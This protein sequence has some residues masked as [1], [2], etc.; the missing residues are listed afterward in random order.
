MRD[1][2]LLACV[3]VIA[4]CGLVYE[5]LSA[6]LASYLLGDSVTQ[7]SL[8]I[9]VYLSAMGLGSYLSK[10]IED[11]I[12]DRFVDAQVVVA[13]FGGFAAPVLFFAFA[14]L[15]TVQPVL[16]GILVVVGTMVGLEIPLVLRILR[17]RA[18]LREVVARVLAL[19]YLGALAASIAFPLLL[20]PHLG[21]SRTSFLFGAL[22]AAVAVYCTFA[23]A[24]DMARP[25]GRRA[26]ALA[27]LAV[28][29]AGLAAGGRVEA[30]GEQ[31]LYDAPV[32]FTRKT[33]Y[34]RLTLTR[35]RGDLRLYINGN[36][37][38]SSLD[39]YR[40]HEALVHPVMAAAAR[41]AR[42]LVLGGGDGLALR[43]ILRHPG[44]EHV[45]LVDLDPGMTELFSQNPMLRDLNAGAF[46]DPRVTVV[47]DDA[48][49][50]LRTHPTEPGYDV[51]IV[52]LPDPNNFSLG[53]L[54]SRTFYRTLARHVADGGAVAVQ[55]SSPHLTPR[56]FWCIV[57]TVESAG[58][59]ALP[60]HAFVPSFGEWGFVLAGRD[61]AGPPVRLVNGPPRR[62]L[63]ED[64]LPT[65]FVFPADLAPRDVEPNRLED[66]RLVRYYEED[67]AHGPAGGI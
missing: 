34:Q 16:Y 21:L 48:L 26:T 64:T 47:H 30:E 25:R 8:V 66:Q 9:G 49:N 31:A 10:G 7:F 40:Y 3:F 41:R 12:Y 38:F 14:H 51:V 65:L 5:L 61:L 63:D 6:T 32:I 67:L 11:R 13:I 36:L 42:V 62:F 1:A 58:L 54:Y 56:A 57:R 59:A 2:L 52:D 53:K 39:E 19:D 29:V 24:R 17:E 50:F 15:E 18:S 44:V 28:L 60:Y 4:T 37:Q 46:D 35:Y 23:F 55:A 27:V 22:N 20:L 33:P 43:E 45:D